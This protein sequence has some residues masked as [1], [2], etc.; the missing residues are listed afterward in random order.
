M[1]DFPSAHVPLILNEPNEWIMKTGC[2]CSSQSSLLSLEYLSYHICCGLLAACVFAASGL[3][4]N[5]QPGLFMCRSML[6]SLQCPRNHRRRHTPAPRRLSAQWLPV[7]PRV[8]PLAAVSFPFPP[9]FRMQ[10]LAGTARR[11]SN[12]L[13]SQIWVHAENT[14][15]PGNVT[16]L[17]DPENFDRSGMHE[18]SR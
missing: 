2:M 1:W 5:G 7:E 18:G 17:P 10:Q 8:A 4:G 3:K 11:P 16:L 6:G 15:Q 12:K 9:V 14:V 13:M